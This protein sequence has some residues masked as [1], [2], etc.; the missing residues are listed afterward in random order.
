MF[1]EEKPLRVLVKFSYNS[2]RKSRAKNWNELIIYKTYY[3]SSFSTSI[4]VRTEQLTIFLWQ[5]DTRI[6]RKNDF[7]YYNYY[8]TYI[9]L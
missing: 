5:R 7:V 4:F 3:S 1:R 8:Y 6:L 2:R 9:I